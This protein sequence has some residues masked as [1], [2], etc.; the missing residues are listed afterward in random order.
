MKHEELQNYRCPKCKTPYH[1]TMPRG[2]FMRNILWF[3]SVKKF[4]C[5]R[6]IKAHYVIVSK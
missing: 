2:W 1:Y 3:I 4:L 6:C 5:A